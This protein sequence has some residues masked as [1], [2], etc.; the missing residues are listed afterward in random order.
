MRPTATV[1]Q[2]TATVPAAWP[3]S[4]DR[5]GS[6]GV[7]VEPESGVLPRHVAWFDPSTGELTALRSF[8]TVVLY[9][10]VSGETAYARIR[11]T[12]R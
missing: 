3:V 8:G 2:G 4:V 1:T 5:A 9:A 7:Y 6:P 11:L 12:S 10:T